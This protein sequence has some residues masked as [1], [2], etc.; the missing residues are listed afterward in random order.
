M[1][2]RQPGPGRMS[3]AV[4][5]P[6]LPDTSQ[7]RRGEVPLPLRLVLRRQVRP[8]P[9]QEGRAHLQLTFSSSD[10]LQNLLL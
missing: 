9:P 10:P 7:G 5:R 2:P 6:R 4:L 3:A 1:Q 8:V